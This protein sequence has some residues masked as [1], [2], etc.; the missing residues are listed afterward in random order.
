M[1]LVTRVIFAL[2]LSTY[3]ITSMA[4]GSFSWSCPSNHKSGHLYFDPLSHS[5]ELQLYGNGKFHG[6]YPV[7]ITMPCR[8]TASPRPHWDCKEEGQGVH[9]DGPHSVG[10]DQSYGKYLAVAK[11]RSHEWMTNIVVDDFHCR[12]V[13]NADSS[14]A[15]R[16]PAKTLHAKRVGAS[17]FTDSKGRIYVL[18]GDLDGGEPTMERLNPES[19]LW[20]SIPIPAKRF[21]AGAAVVNGKVFWVGGELDSLNSM[22]Y[23]TTIVSY[24]PETGKW[25]DEGK[26]YGRRRELAVAAVGSSIYAVG[27]TGVRYG[28]PAPAVIPGKGAF[29]D[30]YGVRWADVFNTE[31]GQGEVLPAN[32]HRRAM[33]SLI[34]GKDGKLY[35]IGG[36]FQGD[37]YG[38]P[39]EKVAVGVMYI[40]PT[41]E[42]FDPATQTWSEPLQM[43]TAR[44]GHT[45]VV[46]KEGK[47]VLVGGRGVKG[48]MVGEVETYEPA[49]RK[50]G[51]GR[52]M[53]VPVYEHAATLGADGRVYVMG[54]RDKN[55]RSR[56]IV[57][58]YDPATDQWEA[59]EEPTNPEDEMEYP[60]LAK[61]FAS[62]SATLP[63][64]GE[65]TG[66]WVGRCYE[67]TKPTIPYGGLL[68]VYGERD[69]V[70]ISALRTMSSEN[71]EYFDKMDSK[72]KKEIQA[73]LDDKDPNLQPARV[74]DGS[75]SSLYRV[76]GEFKTYVYEYQVK[77][78]GEKYLTR[79]VDLTKDSD[80]PLICIHSRKAGQ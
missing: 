15:V 5:A 41:I 27:G 79:V 72:K 28:S 11:R 13:F 43:Q 24:D 8:Y 65:L 63:N 62:D 29:I 26:L 49:A 10:I 53:P 77:K 30:A 75:L 21:H 20:T 1:G 55:G 33:S 59:S 18:G 32:P 31:S 25:K 17:A 57:Q 61:L 54:G 40:N 66:W 39:G 22:K 9:P 76:K 68:A 35:S 14:D 50:W 73:I 80:V 23:A 38:F 46:D 36:Y 34:A 2:V 48:V 37:F 16:Q 3:C 4:S 56:A 45:T 74:V 78:L 12:R 64:P 6:G 60:K 52:A 71:R 70:K 42:A 47:F 51:R 69:S 44:Y 67:R 19:G 7:E 58:V